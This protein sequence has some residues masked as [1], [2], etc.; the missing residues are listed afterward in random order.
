MIR[1]HA[2][3][4]CSGKPKLS[5]GLKRQ[6]PKKCGVRLSPNKTSIA[7][8]SDDGDFVYNSSF[9]SADTYSALLV[10]LESALNKCKK[11]HDIKLPIG[12]SIQGHETASTGMITSLYHPLL[13]Q[14]M[15][16]YDLQAALN[17]PILVASDGQCMAVAART[18]LQL[19]NKQTIFALSLDQIVCGGIIV[20][21][22]LLIGQHG[23]AGD[24][25]HLSLP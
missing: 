8:I 20:A 18:I 11:T 10:Q 14:T 5:K 4:C 2:N 1:R 22:R 12:V 15:L 7:V 6:S 23:L 19:G 24:W 3:T 16:R 21:D 9:A 13:A 17:H 25:G